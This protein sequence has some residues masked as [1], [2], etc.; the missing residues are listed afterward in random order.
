MAH[1][2]V[3]RADSEIKG[4]EVARTSFRCVCVWVGGGGEG[5]GVLRRLLVSSLRSPTSLSFSQLAREPAKHESTNNRLLVKINDASLG[6]R[7]LVARRLI[8]LCFSPTSPHN[9]VH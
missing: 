4:N 6:S 8:W 3:S 2:F 9:L 1:V 7:L 5:E